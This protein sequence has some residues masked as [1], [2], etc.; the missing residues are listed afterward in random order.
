MGGNGP[1]TEAMMRDHWIRELTLIEPFPVPWRL[2]GREVLDKFAVPGPVL[3][4]TT[5]IPM[6]EVP[7]RV[8]MELGYPVPVPV[9]DPGRIVENERYVVPG[10]AERIPALPVSGHVLA[11]ARTLLLRGRSVVCLADSE[12]AG[13]LSVNPMRLASRVG[14]PIVFVWAELAPDGV[15]EVHFEPASFPMAKGEQEIE[16]NLQHLR[17]ISNRLLHQ[18]GAR[19]APIRQQCGSDRCT[20]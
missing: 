11:R 19:T 5:H 9:A 8:V 6:G 7:L 14:V 13:E 2:H 1:L 12:F 17:E 18:L 15:V 16:K 3:Y 20:T 4:Y 10:M